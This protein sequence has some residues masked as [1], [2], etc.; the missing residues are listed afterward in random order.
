LND[1]IQVQPDYLFLKVKILVSQELTSEDIHEIAGT[2]AT[3]YIEKR[4]ILVEDDART[5]KY[6]FVLLD[7]SELGLEVSFY[8]NGRRGELMVWWAKSDLTST[9]ALRA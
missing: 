8:G 7:S 5:T 1:A 2:L 6:L 3:T 4:E 9:H